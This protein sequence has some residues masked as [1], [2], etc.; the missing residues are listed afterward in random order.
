V[1]AAEG[2]AFAGTDLE[3]PVGI[4]SL[5]ELA[6]QLTAASWWPAGPVVV[7]ASRADARS[8]TTRC[9]TSPAGHAHEIRLASAQ[10]TVATLAHELAHVVAGL[11]AGHGPLFRSAYLDVVAALTNLDSTDRRREL[12][13]LQ[14]RDAFASAGLAVAPRRWPEPP[15]AG[16]IAL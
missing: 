8:S 14:L 3:M 15:S 6:A 9:R 10:S 16:P 2:E 4:A 1:Y 7:R 13:V 11:A 5:V 12:H